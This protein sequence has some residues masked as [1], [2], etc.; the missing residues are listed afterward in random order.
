MVILRI[1]ISY[2]FLPKFYGCSIRGSDLGVTGNIK[3]LCQWRSCSFEPWNQRH[4][5]Q[6]AAF[7]QMSLQHT[8][9]RLEMYI[10]L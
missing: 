4:A 8:K 9:C 3:N 6:V 5:Q 1:S 10:E 7:S 2:E